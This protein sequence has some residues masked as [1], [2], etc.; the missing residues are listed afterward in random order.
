[1]FGECSDGDLAVT[2]QKLPVK[3][4]HG[5]SRR[6]VFGQLI[7][8]LMHLAFQGAITFLLPGAS[9]PTWAHYLAGL[10]IRFDLRKR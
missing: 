4:F 5:A 6:V 3:T 9:T 10:T 1:M 7:E 2:S 8:V